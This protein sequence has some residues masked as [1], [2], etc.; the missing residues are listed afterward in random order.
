MRNPPLPLMMYAKQPGSCWHLVPATLL[1]VLTSVLTPSN[2]ATEQT[3]SQQNSFKEMQ[4]LLPFILGAGALMYYGI[5]SINVISLGWVFKPDWVFAL[6]FRLR[7]YV[8]YLIFLV[9]IWLL[10]GSSMLCIFAWLAHFISL[11][12]LSPLEIGLVIVALQISIALIHLCF[13]RNRLGLNAW[14]IVSAGK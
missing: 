7:Y 1:V 2:A 8:S 14:R 10:C 6:F 4:L 12:N 3:L 13:E 11:E 9:R 5:L